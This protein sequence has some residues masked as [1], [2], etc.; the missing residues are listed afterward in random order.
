MAH[1]FISY[2]REDRPVIEKLAA[3]LEEAGH[4]VWWDRHIRGGAAFAKDIE[5]QLEKA[6]AVI[7]AW[8]S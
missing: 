6:D 7:V 4:S 5:A 2:S 1:L 3:A 8:S